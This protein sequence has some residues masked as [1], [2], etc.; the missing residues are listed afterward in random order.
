MLDV[1]LRRRQRLRRA[2]GRRVAANGL[3]LGGDSRLHGIQLVED[4]RSVVPGLVSDLVN[5]AGKLQESCL[6]RQVES[7]TYTDIPLCV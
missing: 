4:D 1:L 2:A 7:L 5:V 6:K 3:L